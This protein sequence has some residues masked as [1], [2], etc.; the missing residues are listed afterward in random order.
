MKTP[1]LL[2]LYQWRI[3]TF[4]KQYVAE[5]RISPSIEEIAVGVGISSTSVVNFNLIKLEDFGLL[6][7]TRGV[8][9]S[10][11]LQSTQSQVAV[12]P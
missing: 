12:M 7:R 1:I 9:R 6:R 3:L 4:L 10:I 8:A 11:V 5:H 2:S